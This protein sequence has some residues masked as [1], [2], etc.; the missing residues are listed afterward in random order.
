L[1]TLANNI[2]MRLLIILGL[3]LSCLTV[4]SQTKYTDTVYDHSGNL[5]QAGYY[6]EIDSVWTLYHY[7]QNG[8]LK[9]IETLGPKGFPPTGQRTCFNPNGNV[10]YM[11]LFDKSGIMYGPFLEFY[12][13]GAIK[14][15][16]QFFNGFKTGTWLEYN[17]SGSIITKTEYIMEKADS[18]YKFVEGEDRL[19]EM[20]IK[21]G[22][23]IKLKMK[24]GIKTVN[25]GAMDIFWV[26]EPRKKK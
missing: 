21:Y 22:Q 2:K 8:Q 3:F 20:K 26:L 6:N 13:D 12:S 23:P 15:S 25:P 4:K 9:T 5:Q 19:V 18:T 24:E 17:E 1:V 11:L 16:G 14:K 7:Y 10:A